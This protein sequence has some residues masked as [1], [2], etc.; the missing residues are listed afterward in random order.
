MELYYEFEEEGYSCCHYYSFGLLVPEPLFDV[1]I[2]V[3][4]GYIDDYI[5]IFLRF[6]IVLLLV[7]H[8]SPICFV[9]LV[10]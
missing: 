4:D 10:L 3:A 1:Y 9:T 7:L 6:A 5:W 8:I 2:Y